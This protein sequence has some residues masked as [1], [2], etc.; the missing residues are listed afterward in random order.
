MAVGCAI[1]G[2]VLGTCTGSAAQ[3]ASSATRAA[4]AAV[5]TAAA[6]VGTVAELAAMF[7]ALRG[8]AV[9]KLCGPHREERLRARCRKQGLWYKWKPSDACMA[10]WALENLPEDLWA[11]CVLCPAERAVMLA[12]TSKR[13]WGLLGRLRPRVP[14]VVR[15]TR[16]ASMGILQ[17]IAS[18]REGQGGWRE[19][20][21]NAP[22]SPY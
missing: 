7:A 12:A 15:M 14:A 2:P 16:H 13:V 20:C 3:R 9:R 1:S 4:A 18:E 5:A 11:R 10:K 17:P 21:G 8:A 19:C 6:A 22:P